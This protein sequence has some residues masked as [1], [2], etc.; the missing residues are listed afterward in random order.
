VA[1][2]V[3]VPGFEVTQDVPSFSNETVFTYG[4][5]GPQRAGQRAYKRRCFVLCRAVLQF[6]KFATFSGG[7]GGTT[8]ADAG[9]ED[10][11]HV[12]LA[13]RRA[14]RKI[15]RI[16]AWRKAGEVSALAFPGRNLNDLTAR[17]TTLFQ[18][19][20]GS[21]IPAYT[22]VGNWRMIGPMPRTGQARLAE[23]I[24]RRIARGELAAIYLTRFHRLNHCVVAYG[25]R[26]TDNGNTDFFVYDP[27][28]PRSGW[29]LTYAQA[30][31]SFMMPK[32]FYF[33][34]GRVNA[35]EVY[36]SHWK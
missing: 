4:G 9:D 26:E 16:P 17:Y 14:I 34:G 22:R 21:W 18:E 5:A 31:S 15:S 24:R 30:Q 36:T 27:N 6:H 32:V 25:F 35:L 12:E 7:G 8:D 33:D 11:G 1:L 13:L 19:E 28:L 23:R 29:T 3:R 20:L 10:A 2:E